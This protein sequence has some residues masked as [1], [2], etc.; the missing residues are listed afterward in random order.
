MK[1]LSTS[2]HLLLHTIILAQVP[3]LAPPPY[4]PAR[5]QLLPGLPSANTAQFNLF[6]VL[7]LSG[8]RILKGLYRVGLNSLLEISGP[9][10]SSD[11]VGD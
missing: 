6:R 2:H 1:S 10:S 7:L 9:K 5:L 3:L 11:H 4:W 8:G